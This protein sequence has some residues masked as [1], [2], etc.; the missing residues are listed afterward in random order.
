MMEVANLEKVNIT[1]APRM[2]SSMAYLVLQL[3]SGHERRHPPE[4]VL[5]EPSSGQSALRPHTPAMLRCKLAVPS[6]EAV[7][8]SN[9]KVPMS[10]LKRVAALWSYFLLPLFA[11]GLN[12][13]GLSSIPNH[14][15]LDGRRTRSGI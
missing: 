9:R 4:V 12:G 5:T 14:R 10:W 8:G 11:V 1:G 3:E 13:N 7:L 15:L 2:Q 6:R